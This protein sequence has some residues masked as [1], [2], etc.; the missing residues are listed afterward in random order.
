LKN[1]LSLPNRA[2]KKRTHE[3][4]DLVLI[5]GLP[6][7][8]KSTIAKTLGL[9]GYQH[10]EADM[11]FE[12]EGKYI[13]DA[14]RIR[15]A[16]D[17]CQRS[18]REALS[19]NMKVVVSNTFTRHQELSPYLQMSDNVQIFEAQ[20]NWKNRHDVPEQVIRNMAARWEQIEPSIKI[21]D[22][23]IH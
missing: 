8:G 22:P 2:D 15:Y 9:V 5:R 13:Y 16:H 14:S 23:S 11:Y 21:S 18:A 3:I 7:S 12:V 1:T 4:A 17:W 20:G 19:K 10:F 6:G